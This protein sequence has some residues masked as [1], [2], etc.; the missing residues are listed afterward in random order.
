MD[1]GSVPYGLIMA[2][3]DDLPYLAFEA[4]DRF[5]VSAFEFASWGCDDDLMK[6]I[7]AELRDRHG[8][9]D[10]GVIRWRI[11]K[12]AE[13]KGDKLC[14]EFPVFWNNFLVMAP[15]MRTEVGQTEGAV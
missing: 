13:Q 8:N 14:E 3:P 4:L 12:R 7:F 11:C 10:C 5:T 1:R 6:A 2:I 9:L 15:R